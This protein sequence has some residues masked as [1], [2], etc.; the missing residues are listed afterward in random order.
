MIIYEY[1]YQNIHLNHSKFNLIV[2]PLWDHKTLS[3]N[4][5]FVVFFYYSFCAVL[6]HRGYIKPHKKVTSTITETGLL[7]FDFIQRH[8]RA[9]RATH[10]SANRTNLVQFT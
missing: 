7:V 3:N 4:Y 5:Y 2:Q 10:F 8:I 1:R 6:Q 9:A